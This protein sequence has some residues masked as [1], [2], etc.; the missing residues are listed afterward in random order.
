MYDRIELMPGRYQSTL[1]DY[2]LDLSRFEYVERCFAM[3]GFFE[4]RIAAVAACVV[5]AGDTVFEGGAHIGTETHNYA[6]LVGKAGQ[7]VSFEADQR[8][9]R[10]LSGELSA[11]GLTQCHV[12][13]KAL[14]E[15]AGVAYFDAAP[16]VGGNSGLGALAPGQST[17]GDH[18]E[19]EVETLDETAAKFGAPRLVVMDIQGGELGALRGAQRLLAEV[20]PFI[21]LE[22]ESR[23]LEVLGASAQDVWDILHENDYTCWRFTRTGLTRVGSVADDELSDWFAV[24]DEAADVVAQV[25]KAFLRGAILPPASRLSPLSSLRR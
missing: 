16:E 5:S 23:C 2:R 18:V 12:R 7:V 8:L 19:V 17:A 4:W 21:V 20:R 6:A 3:R 9:A 11:A 13:P 22:V 24:P 10:S 14:G 1:A 25:K 15:A